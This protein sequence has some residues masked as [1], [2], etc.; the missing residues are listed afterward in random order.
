M[1]KTWSYYK[2]K[3]TAFFI[4]VFILGMGLTVLYMMRP[5]S[6]QG[7]LSEQTPQDTS[8][9][10]SAGYYSNEAFSSLIE[11]NLSELGFL[12]EISFQGEDEGKFIL[13]GQLSEPDRLIAICN[14]LEPYSAL[15][16]ALKN[17]TL[18]VKGHVGENDRGNGC[19]IADTITFSGYTLPAAA[20]TPYIDEYTGLN[21]LLEV[22]FDQISL[23]EKGISFKE[24]IPTVIQTALY[25]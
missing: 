13:K 25:N 2:V 9:E 8:I 3:W 14:E 24:S 15:L 18:T 10:N 21:D 6:T 7:E 20:A 11:D 22:P 23:S 4:T 19:F 16:S 5:Q 12:D 17:E 1:K